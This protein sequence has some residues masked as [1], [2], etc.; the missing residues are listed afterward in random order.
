MSI[1][2]F[3]FASRRVDHAQRSPLL[4]RLVAR[5]AVSMRVAD[6]RAEAF[7][8]LAPQAHGVPAAGVAA[9]L[10]GVGASAKEGG[11]DLRTGAWVCMATP[12]HLVA[13]MTSVR[14]PP[15]GVLELT[16][17]EA[18]ALC[19]EFNR[20][21]AGAGVSLVATDDACLVCVFNKTLDVAT[22]DPEAVQG[23]DVFAFQP[24]GTDA[25][26][27]RRFMS[28]IEMWLH[29]HELNHARCR[30][31]LPPITGLWLWGGGAAEKALPPVQG[32]TAG[33]D[34]LFSAF[35]AESRWPPTPRSGVVVCADA[36]GASG[37]PE[38]EER[39]LA[40]A[41][42]ALR[43][44]AIER[45]DLAAGTRRFSVRKGFDWRLWRRTRPWW[46]SFDEPNDNERP[47]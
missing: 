23:H 21:F 19:S 17:A 37:W 13:G 27:L 46:E 10:V 38:V 36:P 33:R 16:P 22:H 26:P 25:A 34:P 42:A 9:F 44:G 4:E 40:P 29:P 2:Y 30:D 24:S 7:R 5:A 31:L 6:W 8:I 28:E 45:L 47:E 14:M 32:W 3:R 11:G 15:D 1:V 20:G 43:T 12:V 41:A 18:S 35:G 39:W